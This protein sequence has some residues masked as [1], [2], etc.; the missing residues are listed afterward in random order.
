MDQRVRSSRKIV[1]WLLIQA[2]TII[3]VGSGTHSVAM[4]SDVASFWDPKR[5]PEKPDLRQ[6]VQIRFLTADDF[7]PFNFAG[8]DGMPMGFNIDL[9]R[10]IC[11]ELALACTIQARRFDTLVDALIA[12]DGDAVI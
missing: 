8:P 9:A 11:E 6:I 7:P 2:L 4:A 10:A 5:R 3:W 1:F 12:T